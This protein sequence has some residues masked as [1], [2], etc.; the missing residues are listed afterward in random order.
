MTE[1]AKQARREYRRAWAKRNPEKIKAY[2][3]RYWKKQAEKLQSEVKQIE[4]C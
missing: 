3:E 2:Q 4:Y 1:T